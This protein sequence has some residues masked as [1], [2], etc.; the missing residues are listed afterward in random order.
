MVF[1]E[2]LKKKEKSFV[3]CAHMG[4]YRKHMSHFEYGLKKKLEVQVFS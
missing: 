2:N 4:F 1:S 3:L